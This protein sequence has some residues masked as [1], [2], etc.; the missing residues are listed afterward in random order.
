MAGV[1]SG[2]P[3]RRLRPPT[4]AFGAI[5]A[6]FRLTDV[7]LRVSRE[8]LRA[9]LCL[10]SSGVRRLGGFLR[11]PLR[12]EHRFTS[13]PYEILGL[14]LR[15]FGVALGRLGL[16]FDLLVRL[17]PLAFGLLRRGEPFPLDELLGFS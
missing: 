12:L 14:L 1:G 3:C 5:H 15:L 13:L 8:L 17:L 6:G 2:L 9:A 4:N 16:C 10:L 7:L 11:Q